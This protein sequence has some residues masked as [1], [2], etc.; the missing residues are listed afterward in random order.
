MTYQE[1]QPEELGLSQAKLEIV[2]EDLLET[3]T[4]GKGIKDFFRGC[5]S[6]FNPG[7]Q[8]VASHSPSRPQDQPVFRTLSGR[9][10]SIEEG[11]RIMNEVV[12]GQSA[13]QESSKQPSTVFLGRP[14]PQ[15]R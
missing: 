2:E 4:G 10:V 14:H 15:P 9:N 8:E 11:H 7:T 12:L 1:G 3:V 13:P 5:F 6:C